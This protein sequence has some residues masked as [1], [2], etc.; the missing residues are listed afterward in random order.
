MKPRLGRLLR[1]H[2]MLVLA[3][4]SF[5]SVSSA[6][7]ARASYVAGDTVRL[8]IVRVGKSEIFIDDSAGTCS[9]DT[10][11]ITMSK[12]AIG[13]NTWAVVTN[14]GKKIF[15]AFGIV[16]HSSSTWSFLPTGQ[17]EVDAGGDHYAGDSSAPT[18]TMTASCVLTAHGAN[19]FNLLSP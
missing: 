3:G 18:Y 1:V 13:K 6:A 11:V 8:A 9:R 14:G 15:H 16:R 17:W 7:T 4:G 2:A 19:A 10:V 12:S 5:V